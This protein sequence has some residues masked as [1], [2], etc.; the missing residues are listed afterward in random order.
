[1]EEH[2]TP[3]EKR[4]AKPAGRSIPGLEFRVSGE[5]LRVWRTGQPAPTIDPTSSEVAA[6]FLLWLE[7]NLPARKL[8]SVDELGVLYS[9]YCCSMS[10]GRERYPL[11]PSILKHLGTMTDKRQRDV[12]IGDKLHRNRVHYLVGPCAA[13]NR[14]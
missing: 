13:K 14:A 12:N 9:V 5:V 8:V 1:M 11:N 4:S 6:E 2:G 10:G 7:R 3:V